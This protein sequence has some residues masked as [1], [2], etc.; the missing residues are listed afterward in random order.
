MCLNHAEL[1]GQSST[2]LT[3]SIMRFEVVRCG[4]MRFNVK[5]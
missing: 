1:I 4:S 2:H 3:L 5:S